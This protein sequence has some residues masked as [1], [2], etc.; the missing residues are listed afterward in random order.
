MPYYLCEHYGGWTNRQTIAFFLRYCE[1]VFR[2]YQDLVHYWL[3]FNEMNTLVSRFGTLL[4]GGILPEDGEDLFGRKR[5]GSPETAAEKS[6]RFTA[7]HHQFLAGA[8]AVKWHTR[9]IPKIK[10]DVCCLRPVY[11]HILVVRKM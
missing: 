6:C 3:T 4:A 11:I 5:L 9:S 1:T 8:Q 2:E 10:W 7:L